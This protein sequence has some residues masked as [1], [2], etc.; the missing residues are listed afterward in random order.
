[1]MRARSDERD[2]RI[3]FVSTVY[4][5]AAR[6][7]E[8]K[9]AMRRMHFVHSA[10]SGSTI[11]GSRLGVVRGEP[12]GVC[13]VIMV[14]SLSNIGDFDNLNGVLGKLKNGNLSSNGAGRISVLREI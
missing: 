3:G 5:C 1:M 7:N 8:E 14:G 6:F 10:A 4:L 2:A 12:L 9:R 13:Y 11:T